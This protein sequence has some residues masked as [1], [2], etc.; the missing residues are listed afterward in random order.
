[1]PRICKQTQSVS[2]TSGATIWNGICFERFITGRVWNEWR[3][4]SDSPSLMDGIR[5]KLYYVPF[6]SGDSGG[7]CC[8][9]LGVCFCSNC[10]TRVSRPHSSV[11]CFSCLSLFLCEAFIHRGQTCL[12]VFIIFHYDTLSFHCCYVFSLT[13]LKFDQQTG[14]WQTSSDLPNRL[15]PHPVHCSVLCVLLLVFLPL[16]AY[17]FS[18]RGWEGLRHRWK[19]LHYGEDPSLCRWYSIKF[20]SSA[21]SPLPSPEPCHSAFIWAP[22]ATARGKLWVLR[23][24]HVLNW[25]N[26]LFYAA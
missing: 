1:M 12:D 6:I 26:I 18:W 21:I 25:A 5:E 23:G 7:P 2:R 19:T 22:G 10:I 17:L 24:F 11:E 3:K 8:V 4:R 16:F 9:N 13:G 20:Y 14:W 15:E